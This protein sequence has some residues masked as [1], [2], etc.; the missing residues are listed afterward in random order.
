MSSYID[1]Y[2]DDKEEDTPV[3]SK[4]NTILDKY[5]K[6]ETDEDST[7]I[8]S[9]RN[10]VLD[11][12]FDDPDNPNIIKPDAYESD[13]VG[14][15]AWA[16]DSSRMGSL[17]NYMISRFGKEDGSKKEKESCGIL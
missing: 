16:Q 11:K 14:I 15:D 8:K 13:A 1:K 4:P 7:K 6:E 17:S 9:S 5:F 12:Y 3:F 2:F 10:T